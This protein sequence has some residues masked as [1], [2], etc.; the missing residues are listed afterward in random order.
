MSLITGNLEQPSVN[1][2][3]EWNNFHSRN[4]FQNATC[5]MLSIIYLR[6]NEWNIYPWITH[7]SSTC[8]VGTHFSHDLVIILYEITMIQPAIDSL[9]CRIE[10]KFKW[11][12]LPCETKKNTG[13]ILAMGLAN[14]RRCHYV[15]PS[16][17]GRAYAQND[18]WNM[19][20]CYSATCEAYY[21]IM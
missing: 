10:D 7:C 1:F 3:S 20:V 9:Q 16:L 15:T 2:S 18:L 12:A 21:H 19:I 5:K 4:A 14:E 13:I 11:P 6:T 8:S 17:I